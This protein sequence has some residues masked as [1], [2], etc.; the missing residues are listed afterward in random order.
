M[1]KRKSA[2]AK[3]A[4]PSSSDS[5]TAQADL[6]ATDNR[7]ANDQPPAEPS[8]RA[9]S[10]GTSESEYDSDSDAE[11]L[12]ATSSDEVD[13][14]D[15]DSVADSLQG[16]SATEQVASDDDDVDTAILDYAT[17]AQDTSATDAAEPGS[18][19]AM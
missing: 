12:G 9:D 13:S 5:D 6:F 10:E 11:A 8:S 2:G 18:L 3:Q 17:A 15:E 1:A 16:D 7:L 19:T 14:E 4:I